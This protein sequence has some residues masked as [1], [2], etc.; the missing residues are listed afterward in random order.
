MQETD[1]EI[2]ERPD[3]QLGVRFDRCSRL[4]SGRFFHQRTDHECLTLG[5]QLFAQVLV[6]PGPLVFLEPAR[7]DHVAAR[8]QLADDRHVQVAEH[9]QRGGARDGR[10]GHDEVVRIDPEPA[11]AGSLVDPELVLLVDDH[12]AKPGELHVLLHQRLRADD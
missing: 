4:Q 6:E 10:R 2:L 11:D 8:R 1:A 9:G 3:C 7:L 5:E 12:Q